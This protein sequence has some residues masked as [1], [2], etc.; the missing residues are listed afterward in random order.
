MVRVIF[1]CAA[2]AVGIP[3]EV[4]DRQVVGALAKQ[5]DVVT[6]AAGDLRRLGHVL[7]QVGVTDLVMTSGW[8]ALDTCARVLKLP[9]AHLLGEQ[10]GSPVVIDHDRG[11]LVA[12]PALVLVT[13][14]VDARV[15]RSR[16]RFPKLLLFDEDG[17]GGDQISTVAATDLLA[18]LVNIGRHAVDGVPLTAALESAGDRVLTDDSEL[19]SACLGRRGPLR[20]Q[21]VNLQHLYLARVNARLERAIG[22]AGGITADG[23]PVVQLLRSMGHRVQRATGADVVGQMLAEPSVDGLRIAIIGGA[24]APADEFT[25]RARAVGAAVVFREHGDKRD[26]DP[27]VLAGHLQR[28]TADLTLVAVT[29]PIGDLLALELAEAGYQGT[30]IGIGAAVE[31][32]VGGERRAA[33]WLQKLRLEWLVRL[34]Q[35]PR[36][37]WRRYLVEGIPTYVSVVVPRVWSARKAARRGSR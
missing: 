11:V 3:S 18:E 21:T 6:V 35:D 34:A 17:A 13:S 23:W 15:L 28:S 29:Q 22:S 37:L 9:H 16:G 31:L 20:I 2:D 4:L 30:V 26:W 1:V 10:G 7:A 5:C 14:V 33:P 27:T 8:L 25:A 19:M 36:R 32:Y 24:S 12:R